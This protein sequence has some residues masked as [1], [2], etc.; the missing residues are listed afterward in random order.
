M[1]FDPAFARDTNDPEFLRDSRWGGA[2]NAWFHEK[3]STQIEALILSGETAP[4]FARQFLA[5]LAGGR[6]NRGNGGARAART[7]S[8]KRLILHDLFRF[9]HSLGKREE[10]IF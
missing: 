8:E 5:D 6:L 9:R 3:D 2:I 4:D 10:A 1:T 7:P